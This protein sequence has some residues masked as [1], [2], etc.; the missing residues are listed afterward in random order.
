MASQE[1]QAIVESEP[2]AVGLIV[3]YGGLGILPTRPTKYVQSLATEQLGQ[4]R[5]F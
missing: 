5:T 4:S 2:R 1:I 3:G